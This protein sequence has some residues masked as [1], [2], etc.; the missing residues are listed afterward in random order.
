MPHSGFRVDLMRCLLTFTVDG[1]DEFR[2]GFREF[3]YGFLCEFLCDNSRA[4]ISDPPI[5]G[6]PPGDG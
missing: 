3:L 1:V 2:R 6:D 4:A 5:L